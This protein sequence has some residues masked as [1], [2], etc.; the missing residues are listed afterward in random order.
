MPE[1]EV[2]LGRTWF[3]KKLYAPTRMQVL[4]NLWKSK[5]GHLG[6][7][8]SRPWYEESDATDSL[9]KISSIMSDHIPA[10]LPSLLNGGV[11]VTSEELYA[12]DGSIV[13]SE[14]TNGGT[15]VIKRNIRLPLYALN[16]YK[17]NEGRRY[18]FKASGRH[19]ER[20]RTEFG[21]VIECINVDGDIDIVNEEYYVLNG[22]VV[23]PSPQSETYFISF[24]EYTG[25]LGVEANST[26]T[27]VGEPPAPPQMI[28][29]NSSDELME[30]VVNK[31]LTLS[32]LSSMLHMITTDDIPEG[33][34]SKYF[35]VSC[36]LSISRI[37]IDKTLQTLKTS[38][39]Q[40]E[41]ALYFTEERVKNVAS[42]LRI[43]GL[44]EDDASLHFNLSSLQL[45]LQECD[46]SDIKEGDNLYFTY[47]RAI[48]VCKL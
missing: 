39:I 2:K 33:A 15:G 25:R 4:D 21:Y 3:K 20:I 22:H 48:S 34:C 42:T 35:D 31:F 38:D 30:G 7:D 26:P 29:V 11:L 27:L 12:S 43:S 1:V 5:L 23:F 41:G 18:V 45:K 36:V 47:E 13:T 17:N 32:N 14:V 44:N 8:S 46:S 10:T 40:E 19:L 16:A 28:Q 9:I 6:F 37:E 24:F